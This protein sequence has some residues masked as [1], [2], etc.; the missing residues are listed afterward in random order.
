MNFIHIIRDAY[1]MLVGIQSYYI[2][3]SRLV[4][5]ILKS[6]RCLLA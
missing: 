3:R 5:L 1:V 4:S 6:M 2:E